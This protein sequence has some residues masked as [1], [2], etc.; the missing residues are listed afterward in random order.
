MFSSISNFISELTGE[1]LVKLGVA[2]ATI[3]YAALELTTSVS[4]SVLNLAAAMG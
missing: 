1:T 2:L 4:Y 3:V